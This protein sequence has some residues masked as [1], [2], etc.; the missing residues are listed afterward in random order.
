MSSQTIYAGD[1]EDFRINGIVFHIASET[2]FTVRTTIDAEYAKNNR[3]IMATD[4]QNI[5]THAVSTIEPA[6]IEKV[7]IHADSNYREVLNAI[8]DYKL[9]VTVIITLADGSIYSGE[10]LYIEGG[11]NWNVTEMSVSVT[12]KGSYFGKV[13]GSLSGGSTVS[14]PSIYTT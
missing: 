12:F 11:L 3:V 10:N 4:G 1:I 2:S 9:P 5:A 6:G 8:N 7:D 13:N 14:S